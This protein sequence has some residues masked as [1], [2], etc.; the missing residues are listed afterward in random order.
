[1]SKSSSKQMY[2]QLMEWIPTLSSKRSK[3]VKARDNAQPK[4]SMYAASKM[5]D[6]NVKI[7]NGPNARR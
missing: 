2:T 3:P 7:K 4:S 6:Y 1:M 5:V